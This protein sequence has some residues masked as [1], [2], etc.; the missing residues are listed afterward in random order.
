VEAELRSRLATLETE[1]AQ[2]QAVIDGLTRKYMETIEKLQ[3]DKAKL[4]VSPLRGVTCQDLAP[5]PL[6]FEVL[7]GSSAPRLNCQLFFSFFP[8]QIQVKSQTLEK[9]AKECRLRTEEWCVGTM[10][11][12]G[13]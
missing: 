10:W 8:P 7:C 9:E 12:H 4:E 13:L 3:S 5:A 2:H 11:E 1:A 6:S